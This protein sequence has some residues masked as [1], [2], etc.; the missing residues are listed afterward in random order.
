MLP[1]SGAAIFW[2]SKKG[3]EG[4]GLCPSD[5]PFLSVEPFFFCRGRDPMA[6]VA[7]S[8][9]GTTATTGAA[10]AAAGVAAGAGA[11]AAAAAGA[12]WLVKAVASN[13]R[14][15]CGRRQKLGV[16]SATA[17]AAPPLLMPMHGPAAEAL[18]E[19]AEYDAGSSA[20]AE[21]YWTCQES[22]CLQG[23]VATRK[24]GT[25]GTNQP[26]FWPEKAAKK[27]ENSR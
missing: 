12:R 10:G 8:S 14:D 1:Q 7:A 15:H 26:L 5:G 17:G 2:P 13:M 18:H 6:C 3:R 24:N 27:T 21:F 4:K 19:G 23:A 9:R 20:T 16:F 11:A 22:G 25:W